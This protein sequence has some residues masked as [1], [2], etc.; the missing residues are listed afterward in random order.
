MHYKN[1]LIAL[2]IVVVTGTGLYATS[3]SALTADDVQ[4]QI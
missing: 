1:F 4:V 3:V 2:A